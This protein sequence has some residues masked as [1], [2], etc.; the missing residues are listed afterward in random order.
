MQEKQANRVFPGCQLAAE[1]K[2]WP[3]VTVGVE[4][5]LD[6]YRLNAVIVSGKVTFYCRNSEPPAWGANLEF[7]A[8]ELLAMGFDDCMVDG[9][10]MA[11]DW[12]ATGIIRR[13]T[14]STEQRALLEEKVKFW[15]FDLVQFDRIEKQKVGRLIKNVDPL[16]YSERRVRLYDRW[17]GVNPYSIR[18]AP[19]YYAN[20]EAELHDSYERLIRD[21][22]E[23]AMVKLLDAPYVMDRSSG[24][25]K[26]KPTKTVEMKITDCVEGTGKYVGMLGA[27]TCVDERGVQVSVGTGL[28]DAQRTQFWVDR[29]QMV[30]KIIEV[31]SQDLGGGACTATARHPVFVRVREDRVAL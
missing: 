4:P 9:E 28:V 13:K 31:K 23:G 16:P 27:F 19:M 14:L 1:Y 15:V 29:E 17:C 10:I 6:G 12:N 11:D 25:Q 22:H 8:D 18:L 30:G 3:G 24:W 5:K 20:T 26:M 7:I 2:K 21:G